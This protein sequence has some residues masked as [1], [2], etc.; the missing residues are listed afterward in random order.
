MSVAAAPIG[1]SAPIR[2]GRASWAKA[3]VARAATDRPRAA[4]TVDFMADASL[5]L[6]LG[7]SLGPALLKER[8]RGLNLCG[9][10]M[11]RQRTIL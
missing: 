6:V 9:A 11:F 7:V 2:S 8:G 10:C 1:A 4:K 3:G 5:K